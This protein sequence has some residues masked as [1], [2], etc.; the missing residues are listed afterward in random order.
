MMTPAEAAARLPAAYEARDGLLEGKTFTFSTE[1][2]T[3]QLTTQ[4]GPWLDKYIARLERRASTRSGQTHNVG[5]ANFN[6]SN[7]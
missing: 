2:G 4:D 3:R 1:N 5:V 6:H 7:R